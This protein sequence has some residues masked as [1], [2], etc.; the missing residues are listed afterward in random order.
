MRNYHRS[1]VTAFH[2]AVAHFEPI[3]RDP[4]FSRYRS[5]DRNSSKSAACCAV[6]SRR[7]CS[8]ISDR[9]CGTRRSTSGAATLIVLACAVLEHDFILGFSHQDAAHNLAVPGLEQM[10]HELRF[11]RFRRLENV[12]EQ[13]RLAVLGSDLRKIRTQVL[14]R[15]AGTM[16]VLAL[17]NAVGAI[18]GSAPCPVARKGQHRRAVDIFTEPLDALIGRYEP[19]EKVAYRSLRAGTR[20]LD[21]VLAQKRPARAARRAGR[22]GARPR[23]SRRPAAR[24]RRRAHRK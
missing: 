17:G 11:N 19:L 18:N 24:S 2:S 23:A 13:G 22:A 16:A 6:R 15:V 5:D 8:G 7:R 12:L 1:R 9:G 21:D 14:A 20:D 10:G 4:A 3:T